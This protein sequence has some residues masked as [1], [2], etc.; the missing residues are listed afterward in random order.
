MHSIIKNIHV[1]CVLLTFILF[2]IRGI[3]M[4][5]NSRRLQ[6]RWVKTVPHL[7][8]SVLLIS[9]IAMAIS[10]RQYP[11]TDSWL[12]AKL[13]ALILYIVLGSIALKRGKTR[14]IRISA[15]IGSYFAFFYIIMTA[16]S[17]TPNPLGW[18]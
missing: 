7:L 3:W 2:S 6:L 4:A 16:L 9:G 5:R 11:G 8:D 10:I 13:L 1:T 17:R 12:T 14:K 18:M 15:W